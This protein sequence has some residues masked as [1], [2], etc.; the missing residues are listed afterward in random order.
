MNNYTTAL[1]LI[2]HTQRSYCN[3]FL[4]MMRYDAGLPDAEDIKLKVMNDK[5]YRINHG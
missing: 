3:I 5:L 4:R 1:Q 2:H